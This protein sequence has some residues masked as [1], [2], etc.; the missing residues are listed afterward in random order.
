[1]GKAKVDY[2]LRKKKGGRTKGSAGEGS[3]DLGSRL[4]S[5]GKKKK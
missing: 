2:G 5:S 1:M 3:T 4:S